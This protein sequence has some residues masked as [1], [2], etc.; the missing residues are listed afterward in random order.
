MVVRRVCWGRKRKA[1]H[2]SRARNRRCFLRV[3][4]PS[5]PGGVCVCVCVLWCGA[6]SS[7]PRTMT[8][9]WQA[10]TVAYRAKQKM[11]PISSFE[12]TKTASK[13]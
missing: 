13:H 1:I 10:A 6:A 5:D 8:P 11:D 12:T 9:E 7:V 4:R 2:R 3:F